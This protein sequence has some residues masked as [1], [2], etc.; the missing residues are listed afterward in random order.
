MPGWLFI[1]R[2]LFVAF[3]LKV[4]FAVS[5]NYPNLVKFF[6]WGLKN[7]FQWLNQ[8]LVE[9]LR[10]QVCLWTSSILYMLFEKQVV[11]CCTVIMSIGFDT[12]FSEFILKTQ[13][14]SLFKNPIINRNPMISNNNSVWKID[15]CKRYIPPFVF[16]D[17][18]YAKSFCWISV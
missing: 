13:F 9:V 6:T 4:G 5:I 12:F 8:R 3:G 15:C 16:S 17:L 18:F 7:L 2:S 10:T 14:D 1:F 11:S